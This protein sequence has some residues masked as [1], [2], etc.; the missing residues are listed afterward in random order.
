MQ[1]ILLI[2]A[3]GQLGKDLT[4]VLSRDFDMAGVDIEQCDITQ[5]QQV[6]A[7]FET[8]RPDIAI[9]TAA[10][11]DVPA[12]ET[13]D[14]KA[15]QINALGAKNIAV[16]CERLSCKLMH[17]STDY[18]FDGKKNSPYIESDRPAPLNVYGL[19]KLTGE[20]YV[21]AYC[22][23]HFIVRTSGLYGIYPAVGKKTNFVETMLKL[24]K[25][26]DTVKVVDDEVLTPTFTVNLAQQIRML[27]TENHYGIYHATNNGA[28][29]W[30]QF[31]EKIFDLAQ[32]KTKL[33]KTS[34][35][36]F[37]STVRRPGY[38]VLENDRL[39]QRGI[40]IMKKWEDA[41]ADYFLDK[42]NKLNLF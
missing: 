22:T 35:K 9:N 19:S 23:R 39:K 1:K 13:N 27:I 24:A 28:C 3:Q 12:C 20:Y 37:A 2:G 7:L 21:K 6:S 25:E 41:L 18:V 42:E 38:S 31:T 40:D 34:V 17:I 36:E 4:R 11:T 16:S 32:I 15:F 10:W 29:S 8:I 26:N 30:Y 5:A 33:E 14:E